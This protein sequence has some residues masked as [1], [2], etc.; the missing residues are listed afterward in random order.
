MKREPNLRSL[1]TVEGNCKVSNI[2]NDFSNDNSFN[3]YNRTNSNIYEEAKAGH[4]KI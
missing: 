2:K 3:S 1:S 4:K